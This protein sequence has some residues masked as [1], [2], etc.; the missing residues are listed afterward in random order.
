MTD[1][2]SVIWNKIL[3]LQGHDGNSE[4]VEVPFLTDVI[5]RYVPSR[6]VGGRTLYEAVQKELS[7]EIP[8][9]EYLPTLK[10][11]F[12]EGYER[13]GK[14]CTAI[15]SVQGDTPV[16]HYHIHRKGTAIAPCFKVGNQNILL[17][18]EIPERYRELLAELDR[19]LENS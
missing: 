12:S 5:A 11:L 3:E 9:E 18:T 13:E 4:G 15:P 8:T 19:T 6:G 17:I 16:Y 7:H 10:R 1:L 2:E 14:V